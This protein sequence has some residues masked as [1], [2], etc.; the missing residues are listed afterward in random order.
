MCALLGVA[1]H[2]VLVRVKISDGLGRISKDLVEFGEMQSVFERLECVGAF[3]MRLGR[4][5][6]VKGVLES[7]RGI[8]RHSSVLIDTH[9][10]S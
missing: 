4:F 5:A 8:H 3:W 1:F 6:R 2:T 9:R 7:F 10:H